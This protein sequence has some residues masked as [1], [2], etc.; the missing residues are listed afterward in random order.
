VLLTV[1]CFV[2]GSLPRRT[3]D[4]LRRY[5]RAWVLYGVLTVA[6]VIVYVRSAPA[7]I[8][9]RRT[10]LGELGETAVL[11]SLGSTMVG[12]PWRWSLFGGG[13][14]SY[15]A[16]PQVGIVL[17]WILLAGFVVWAWA[18]SER[19]LRMLWAP[20]FYVAASIVLVYVGRAYVLSILG[21]GQVGRHV[22]YLSDAAPVLVLALV[23]M[24]VP[25]VGA[26]D[27]LRRRPRALIDA[28]RPFRTAP[29]LFVAALVVALLASSV[30][31]SVRY[32][33]PWSQPFDQRT[34][35]AGAERTIR[36]G[37]PLLADVNVPPEAQ[38]PLFG[39]RS[40]IRNY[41]APLGSA[42]RVTRTGNDLMVLDAS[43]AAIPADVDASDRSGATTARS[44][45]IRV[46]GRTRTIRLVPVLDATFWMAIDYRSDTTGVLPLT[47]GATRRE[48][49]IEAGRHTLF[50]RT[51]NAYATVQIRPL[52]GQELCVSAVRVGQIVPRTA[53]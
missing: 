50:V 11:E 27:P 45:P 34:F 41:L 19:A 21:S 23:G 49:P 24:I 25:I 36:A 5:W 44:C 4:A 31:T 9:A 16:A 6:F 22:Q 26:A 35:T 53:S 20:A 2:T 32:A 17:A 47:I 15:A 1:S 3:W 38:S 39:D 51:S 46:E 28:R 40:L 29:G 30:V 7:T 18:R 37:S 43:G 33:S 52:V 8:P 13:P 12:G 14:I 10:S 48:V 42:L